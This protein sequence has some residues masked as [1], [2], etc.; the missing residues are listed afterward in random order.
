VHFEV[1]GSGKTPLICVHGWGCESGQFAK[2]SETLGDRFRIFRFD[3]PG[4]GKTPLNDFRPSFE[5][6]STCVVNFA[7]EHDL[8]DFVLLGHSMGG[9]LA[10][11]AAASGR[12]RLQS[13][14]NLDGGLPPAAHTLSGQA[15]I[16]N[17]LDKPDF[18]ERLATAL[19]EGFFLPHERDTRC[20]AIIRTMC[21]APDPVLRFLPEQVTTLDATAFLP[22]IAV[23]ALYIG[24]EKARFD[25][26]GASS[27][28]PD[29]RVEHL[30]AGHFLHIYALPR[31]ITLIDSFMN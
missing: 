16:R 17:W 30:D 31:V 5:N 29:V 10:L 1:S 25:G 20:E 9:V 15:R 14:I 4:H 19:R 13:I 27:L 2:L 8:K 21:S 22:K 11:M 28:T 26:D 7:I 18:R 23:P 24:S 12:L 6:Y 3:L